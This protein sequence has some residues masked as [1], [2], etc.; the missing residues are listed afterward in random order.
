MDFESL[1]V[2][3]EEQVI[4]HGESYSEDGFT[5]IV[6]CCEPVDGVQSTDFRTAG[7]LSPIYAGSTA[8]RAGTS[9]ALIQLSASDGGVFNLLSIDL[10][11]LPSTQLIGDEL[12]PINTGLPQNVTFYGNRVGG[13]TVTQSVSHDDFLTLTTYQFHA[14]TLLTSVSWFQGAGDP[15]THQFDMCG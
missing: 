12:V 15:Y 10:A 13:T 4:I 14:F 7:T 5:L 11:A 9:N 1:R 2:D 8:M 6:S 3:S